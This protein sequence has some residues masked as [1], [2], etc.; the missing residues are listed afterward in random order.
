MVGCSFPGL[1]RHPGSLKNAV[2]VLGYCYKSDT[3]DNKYHKELQSCVSVWDIN[4]PHEV[5]NL[6]KH[7]E[8]R[9]ELAEKMK[10]FSLD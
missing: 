5:Q 4:L 6:K 2:L 9:Q 7:I 1:I 8:M 3:E 10:S